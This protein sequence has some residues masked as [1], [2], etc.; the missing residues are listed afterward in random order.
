MW[1]INSHSATRTCVLCFADYIDRLPSVHLTVCLYLKAQRCCFWLL[2]RFSGPE[3]RAKQ[4]QTGGG[5]LGVDELF[6][7]VPPT[8]VLFEVACICLCYA[9]LLE[10]QVRVIERSEP[11][12]LGFPRKKRAKNKK[13]NILLY[14]V[15]VR[16]CVRACVCVCVCDSTS[17][18]VHRSQRTRHQLQC[19]RVLRTHAY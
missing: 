5:A 8:V 13:Q 10:H 4:K 3:K 15:C 19:R 14:N 2:Q 7:R 17:T 12:F 9:L 6:E 11:F 18:S 16:A 1:H